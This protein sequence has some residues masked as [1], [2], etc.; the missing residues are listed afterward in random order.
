MSMRIW[1]QSM[2]PLAHLH[3]YGDALR[4]C[5]KR[6]CSP[7]VEVSFNG[8][9]EPLYHNRTPAD[10]LKYPYAKL[11][12]QLEAIDFCRK[13][14]ADGFDAVILGSFSEPFLPEMRSV[15]T[16]PVVS[17]A[18]ASLVTSCSLAEQFAL[19]TLAPPNVKRLRAL[20][21][22]HG[23]EGRVSGVY[24]LSNSVNEADLDA[25]LQSPKTVAEDFRAV[26]EH[27][28]EAGAD[29]VVPA[30]G[31]L[32]LIVHRSGIRTVSR[33]TILDSVATSLLH[34][35]FL[36]TLK[37]RLGTGVGRR[38][39]YAHPPAELLRDLDAMRR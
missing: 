13:A 29:V 10:V 12:A 4:D 11:V 33:A 25:A 17:L 26:A 32:N 16:I 18:E 37:R 27:A 22:R 39:G 8:M 5:A 19:V 31:V 3:N 23:M 35:E 2:T 15:L 24:A 36:V 9:S 14:E 20:V 34:A 7:G 38:W 21:R 30:E 28:V 6:V 1:Y